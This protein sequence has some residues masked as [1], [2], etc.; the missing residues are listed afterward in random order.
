MSENNKIVLFQL[1][2]SPPE[3]AKNCEM[4]VVSN[5]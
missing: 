4:S 1:S 3:W 2:T 5:Q